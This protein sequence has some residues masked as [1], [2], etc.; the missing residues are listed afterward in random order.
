MKEVNPMEKRF[1]YADNAATTPLDP[2]VLEKMMPYL[3][4]IYGNPS[5][6]HQAGQR[7]KA[8]VDASRKDIADCIG[9]EPGE[10]YITAG[11]SESDNWII[12]ELA[13]KALRKGQT[14]HIIS[15]AFEHHAVL[16]SLEESGAEVTL[17]P[18]YENGI[19]KPEDL[20]AAIKDNTVLVTVMFGNNEIGSIQPI[21]ELAEITHKHRGVVFHTDAVQALGHVPINVKE[22]GIDAMS[23]SAHKFNGPKG[24]GGMYLRKGIIL[25]NLISGG[26]QEKGK[27]A[28]TENPAGIVGMAEA[29]KLACANMEENTKKVT[30]MRDRLIDGILER[31]PYARVNGDR[32]NRLPGNVNVSIPFI[33]G[34][35]LLLWLDINGI[36]ASSGS[37]CTSGSLDPSH[38]LLSIGLSHE[39]AHG[40]LRFSLAHTNSEEDV[41]YIL[42]TLPGIVQRL[43]DMSPLWDTFQKNNGKE[44]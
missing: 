42:E 21:K 5:S 16:H 35:S 39:I 34:E 27:R 30:A 14:P 10:I 8:S 31:I 11:G 4:E 18:V 7:A 33:E 36:C 28:G 19:V 6:V 1:V 12:K 32:I 3:T 15:T 44:N 13:V 29:L 17:L 2:R 37:A 38:V 43:R 40:S 24:I 41:D 26:G 22:M 9:A 23:F 20:E 25:P